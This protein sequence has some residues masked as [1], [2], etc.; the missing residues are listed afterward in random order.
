MQVIYSGHDKILRTLATF[1]KVSMEYIDRRLISQPTSYGP[2]HINYDLGVLIR[3]QL[4][5]RFFSSFLQIIFVR[6]SICD[7]RLM[8]AHNS[9]LQTFA[10]VQAKA[11]CRLGV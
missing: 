4:G 10:S 7:D 1:I 11:I 8:L 2:F 5:S 6:T 9:R 3:L